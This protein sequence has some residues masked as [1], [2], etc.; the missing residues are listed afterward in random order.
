MENSIQDLKAIVL[1]HPNL[2]ETGTGASEQTIS[3]AERMIGASFPESL[4]DYL[5]RW[6]TLAAGPLEFYGIPDNRLDLS[7]IPD[8]VW[9]TLQKRQQL[10]LPENFMVLLNNDGDEYHCINLTTGA[11]EVWSTQTR[12]VVG[13]KGDDL[14][15]YL[16]REMNSILEDEFE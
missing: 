8:A 1:A 2:V 13:P 14:F 11:I 5:S 16:V 9:F 6:G 4:R 12:T 15:G 7:K 10:D 3:E